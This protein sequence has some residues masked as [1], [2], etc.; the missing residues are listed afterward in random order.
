[1]SDPPALTLAGVELVRVDVP[2]RTR[3][4][5]AAGVHELRTL[6]FIRVVADEGEGW[7]ECAALA[8]GTSVDPELAIVEQM[9]ADS[10]VPRLAR[11]AASRGGRLPTGPDVPQLFGS[12]AADRVLAAA[13]EMAV[14]DAELRAQGRSLAQSLQIGSGFESMPVG[15]V[16]GIPVDH[17]AAVLRE[18]V[19]RA[20]ATGAARVRLKIEPGWDIDP[21]RRVRVAHPDVALQV[22]ANGSYRIADAV[23]LLSP[24][25]DFDVVC[26]E[27]P[28]PAADLVAHAQLAAQLRVPICLDESLSSPRRVRDALRNGSCAMACLKPARLGGLRA[29]GPR[30][31]SAWRPGCLPSSGASSRQGWAGPPTLRWPPVSARTRP[32]WSVTSALRP[33]T[34]RSTPAGTPRSLPGGSWCLPSPGSGGGP[35]RPSSTN[36]ACGVAGFRPPTLDRP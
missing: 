3:L 28:L 1:M 33:T 32:A 10:A 12:S 15:A 5:T 27:Q 36:S 35:M 25:A 31:Q 4:G 7:G 22:D 26:V 11:A 21:V 23:E 16:V 17:D 8:G 19:D 2:F 6:L 14:A 20:V 24:L 18:E 29:T 13:F 30:M 9:A 34:S